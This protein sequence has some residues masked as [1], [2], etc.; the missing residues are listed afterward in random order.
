M[1]THLSLKIKLISFFSMVL[2]VFIHSYTFELIVDAN[3]DMVTT[4][5][6]FNTFIQLYLS[7]GIA[8]IAV[9][10]FFMLSG[11]LFFL[12]FEGSSF[13]FLTKIKKRVKTVLLPYLIWSAWGILFYLILQSVPQLATFFTN[14]L[15]KD[16]SLSEFL[17]TLFI[18]PIAPQLWFLRDLFILVLLTPILYYL[19]KKSGYVLILLLLIP[20]AFKISLVIISNEALLFFTIGAFLSI[21]KKTIIHKDYS[22][23]A[24][25]LIITWLIIILI[26]TILQYQNFEYQLITT[27]I[28]KLSILVGIAAIWSCYEKFPKWDEFKSNRLTFILSLSFFLFA[29]HEP[30]LTIYRK[31]FFFIL[32]K[33]E[34][35]IFATYFLTPIFTLLSGI[36]LA[37]FLKK[38]FTSFYYIISG[39]R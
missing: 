20:W 18:N 16:Y 9:P 26:K 27:L 32:G 15:V 8:R 6:G 35:A 7:F 33:N 10:F 4:T 29:F 21:H 1:N 25:L 38:Y 39:G 31:I 36:L 37:S 34:I 28:H 30:F 2:V 22:N 17:N 12:N 11:F 3:Q 13:D 23:N 14:K 19:V 24:Y 5:K